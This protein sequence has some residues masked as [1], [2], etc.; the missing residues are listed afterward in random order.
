M[1]CLQL[2]KRDVDLY[3]SQEIKLPPS[4][5]LTLWTESSLN[6]ETR[7]SHAIPLS[8][9]DCKIRKIYVRRF[10]EKVDPSSISGIY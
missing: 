6:P 9:I 4:C 1:L 10:L 7:L 5:L 2:M 8:G 3:G